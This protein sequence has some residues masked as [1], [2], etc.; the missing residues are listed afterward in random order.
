MLTNN[1]DLF[2]VKWTEMGDDLSQTGNTVRIPSYIMAI[3]R[4]QLLGMQNRLAKA[5][6]DADCI[7]YYDTDSVLSRFDLYNRRLDAF[8]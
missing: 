4:S 7:G 8:V 1:V 3:A 6:G 5:F 2:E